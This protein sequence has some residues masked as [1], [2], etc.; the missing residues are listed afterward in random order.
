MNES[1]SDHITHRII[2]AWAMRG[3][4]MI[5]L[6]VAVAAVPAQ[7]GGLAISIQLLDPP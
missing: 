3:S 2:V 5:I 1:T 6:V 4:A 7:S